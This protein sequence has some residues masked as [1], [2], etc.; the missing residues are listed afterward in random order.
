M[1]GDSER[2]GVFELLESVCAAGSVFVW[3]TSTIALAVAMAPP[4]SLG[5]STSTRP[6]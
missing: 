6:I 1:V 4:V 2:E 3:F 5:L